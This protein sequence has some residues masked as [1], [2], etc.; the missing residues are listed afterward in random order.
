MTA[1]RL[2]L[3]TL[4]FFAAA[5]AAQ[6][7]SPSLP[8][9]PVGWTMSAGQSGLFYQSPTS[10][11]GAASV[12][13]TPVE[14]KSGDFASTFGEDV[15]SLVED[16]FGEAIQQSPVKKI[17]KASDVTT[18]L[19]STHVVRTDDNA[20][21]RVQ[22]T[23]YS[24]PGGVQLI[25]IVS[26]TELPASAAVLK[27][28]LEFSDR[29]RSQ[30]FSLTAELL[31]AAVATGVAAPTRAATSDE[32]GLSNTRLPLPANPEER[33]EAVIYY[34]RLSFDN[35][36]RVG[37]TELAPVTATLLK[38]GR[39]YEREASAPAAFDPAKRPDG[40]GG[41]GRWEKDGEG[42]SLT[43]TDGESGTAVSSAAKTYPAPSVMTLHGTYIPNGG[44]ASG[45][46]AD[47]L[48]FAADETIAIGVG[49]E[50]SGGAAASIVQGR[51]RISQRTI[52]I[53]PADGTMT[54]RIFGFQGDHERPEVLLIGDRV[55]TRQE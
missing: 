16:L 35:Q 37:D 12:L 1:F 18:A 15:P 3:G 53:T 41:V 24:R 54:S 19:S 2:A 46:W 14:P 47:R 32:E 9:P 23:G 48:T 27:Q 39:A 26:S 4:L 17:S 45:N 40:G 44:T 11:I 8:P 33:I 21:I 29:V 43:F 34:L 5:S 52:E 38:D 28:A 20:E 49:T 22:V 36:G 25:F 42:Y 55:Y 30:N 13:I 50:P 7:A 10:D 51:Y 31:A 6:A